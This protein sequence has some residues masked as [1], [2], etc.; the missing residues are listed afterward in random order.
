MQQLGKERRGRQNTTS[1]EATNWN[2]R[3]YRLIDN[4]LMSY[5]NPTTSLLDCEAMQ[6]ELTAKHLIH[7][8]VMHPALNR[9]R[10]EIYEHWIESKPQ[11]GRS[12]RQ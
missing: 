8:V 7:E 2:L 5:T 6:R 10:R 4:M 11:G 9:E 12:V 3:A 1:R